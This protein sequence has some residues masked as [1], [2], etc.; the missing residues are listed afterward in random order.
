[1]AT[2]R[3]LTLCALLST[4]LSF[5]ALSPSSVSS[6]RHVAA[7]ASHAR[8]TYT[9]W[10]ARGANARTGSRLNAGTYAVCFVCCSPLSALVVL[11]GRPSDLGRCMLAQ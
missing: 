5:M 9:A 6:T 11:E 3:L 8:P 4:A 1:M 7:T 10:G 2:L